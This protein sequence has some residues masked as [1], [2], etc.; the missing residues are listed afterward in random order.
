MR[1][2]L[3]RPSPAMIV[4]LVALFVSLGGN[5]FAAVI[6]TS[7]SQVRDGVLTGADLATGTVRSADVQGLTGADVQTGSLP[8]TKLNAADVQTLL[9]TT[10]PSGGDVGGP[11]SNLQLATDSVSA[12]EIQNGQVGA[13][14]IQ[15]GQVGQA[16]IGT[17]GV[18]AA[19][20]QDGQVGAA[21]IGDGTVGSAEVAPN[22]M[23][24]GDMR[25][26][27]FDARDFDYA[28]VVTNGTCTA[29]QTL[30]AMTAQESNFMTIG[31]YTLV[32]SDTQ[33]GNGWV[34]EGQFTTVAGHA[35]VRVCNYTGVS[36]DPPNIGLA[37]L[38]FHA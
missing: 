4:A 18:A 5:A 19:E 36:A 14:E 17:N 26:F 27:Y 2:F 37:T 6:I 13:A 23:T 38:T 1:R 34:V 7:S 3:K 29:S 32:T 31:A 9:R 12:A 15:D 24:F 33:I 8:L 11:L 22:S 21:E 20:I 28:G 10:T 30:L 16:E 35:Q 25:T